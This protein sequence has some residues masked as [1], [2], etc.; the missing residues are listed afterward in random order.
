MFRKNKAKEGKTQKKDL[1]SEDKSDK[2]EHV[3]DY[4][5]VNPPGEILSS[6]ESDSEIEEN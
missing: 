1:Y 3:D 5:D 2:S 6:A 4:E